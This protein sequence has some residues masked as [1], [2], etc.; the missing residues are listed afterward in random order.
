MVQRTAYACFLGNAMSV[1]WAYLLITRTA[2]PS[3]VHYQ[4]V[5]WLAIASY[6][7][8]HAGILA[9]VAPPKPFGF[10]ARVL[11]L[12]LDFSVTVWVAPDSSSY[13]IRAVLLSLAMAWMALICFLDSYRGVT[14]EFGGLLRWPISLPFAV[15]ALMMSARGVYTLLSPTPTIETAPFV[16]VPHFTPV[17]W[18]FITLIS[19]SNIAMTGLAATRFIAHIRSL[20]DRDFLT[21]CLNRR[22]WEARL[23]IECDR[24]QRVGDDVACI[25]ID[26]DRF[27]AINDKYGHGVGDDA[28]RHTAKLVQAQLRTVDVLGRLGGEEFMVLMPNTGLEGA[29][30][31]AER[32]RRA[33]HATP[34]TPE[35]TLTA[36]F[37]VAVMAKGE[38]VAE[39][40]HRADAAMYLAKSDGRNLVR[41][42]AGNTVP[43]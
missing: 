3:Y 10:F 9:L 7:A 1:A 31:A 6:L 28:L 15:S 22:A 37:G 34:L 38:T 16:A 43:T 39:L 33:L 27:K 4:L 5:E 11:P 12:I 14:N 21:G 19:I 35:I 25:F 29:C 41:F 8:W 42:H 32:I 2:A 26:L 20:A 40:I 24:K 17:L 18:V 36:S 13:K 23:S 30:Q